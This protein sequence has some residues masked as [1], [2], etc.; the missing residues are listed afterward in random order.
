[1][2]LYTH[3]HLRACFWLSWTFLPQRA[4]HQRPDHQHCEAS[5]TWPF[6]V[7]VEVEG[8]EIWDVCVRIL[9]SKAS[10]TMFLT[11][12]L[13]QSFFNTWYLLMWFVWMCVWMCVVCVC[14]YVGNARLIMRYGEYYLTAF[15]TWIE[16]NI[17]RL[18]KTLVVVALV[19][20]LW[21]FLLLEQTIIHSFIHSFISL[22]LERA[23]EVEAEVEEDGEAV[24]FVWVCCV[25][26]RS[27]LFDIK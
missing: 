24:L 5:Q 21:S 16:A 22:N 20:V 9:G 7:V 23:S 10:K 25:C 26:V 1:M 19:C 11:D 15:R 4:R 6:V 3:T 8:E 18:S 17:D 13:N 14:A 2:L 27:M 12:M